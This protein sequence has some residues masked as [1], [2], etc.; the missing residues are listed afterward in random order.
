MT[1]PELD[2]RPDPVDDAS[3]DRL[4]DGELDPESRRAL[5]ARLDIEPDGWRR[6]ALAFLEAQCWRESLAPPARG[7][8]VIDNPPL[9]P[10]RPALRLSRLATAASVLLAFGLGWSMG[11]AREPSGPG[12]HADGRDR[13]VAK[14]ADPP[15]KADAPT[16]VADA[17]T[18]APAPVPKDSPARPVPVADRPRPVVP[19]P[20]RLQWERRGYLVEPSQR[21]VAVSLGD[22][23]KVTI[24]VDGLKVR[25][26]GNRT[27]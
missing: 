19:D 4:V 15:T 27:Y 1:P 25:Y 17:P 8:G 13:L 21:L 2:D 16:T 24:P 14:V 11:G 5:L 20:V 26:V 10:R 23:R 9:R 6:C 18:P 3:I 12:P 7:L 22:G